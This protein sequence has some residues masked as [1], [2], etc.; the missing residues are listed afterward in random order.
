VNDAP[1]DRSSEGARDRAIDLAFVPARRPGL[2]TVTAGAEALVVDDRADLP[3]LL[4]PTAALVWSFVDGSGSLGD[5]AQDLSEVLGADPHQIEHDVVALARD[6]DRLGLVVDARAPSSQDDGDEPSGRVVRAAANEALD[7]RFHGPGARVVTARD[8]AVEVEVRTDDPDLASEVAEALT[9]R[10]VVVDPPCPA[11][12]RALPPGS[13][14][15]Y[16]VLRGRPKGPVTGL[17]L[18]YRSGRPL[19]RCRH[20]E[21][22]VRIVAADV[23][24]VLQREARGAPLLDVVGLA[25][26]GR[27]VA[28]DPLFASIVDGL[29]PGLRRAGIERVDPSYLR[30]R[31]ADDDLDLVGLVLRPAGDL[32]DH[33]TPAAVALG[34]CALAR[35][36]DGRVGSAALGQLCE[37]V[38]AVAP[39]RAPGRAGILAALQE[40]L[41]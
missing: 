4:S 34:A 9:A 8:G 36:I 27:L 13:A 30:L 22:M 18:L 20:R 29:E 7:T 23:V 2:A 14:P 3:H 25:R 35:G 33:D 40:L 11:S 1:R 24:A 26:H 32:H 37:V 31:P 38:A 12:D 41:T 17:Q 10:L 16:S 15:L 39:M 19:R 5:F 28:V 6:L 21:D